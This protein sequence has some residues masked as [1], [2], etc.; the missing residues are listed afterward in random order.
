ME[1]ALADQ[2][3]EGGDVED[4]VRE[5]AAFIDGF[6]CEL[7]HHWF[8]HDEECALFAV[9]GYGRGE[10]HPKSDIDLLIL[11]KE[12]V[13]KSEHIG[14]FIRL[15]WDLKLEIGH[16]V[17][18]VRDCKNEAHRDLSVMT[19]LNERRL[20]I[21]SARLA[22]RLE[23]A[24]DSRFLWPS[25]RFFKGKLDEQIE[26]HEHFSDIEYG[27]EPNIKSSP[28]GLRD[29]QT[30]GWIARQH[31]QT[32]ELSDLI[33]HGFLTERESQTLLEG[34][35]FLWR[36]R[37]ALHLLAG[38]KEDQLY[39]ELQRD[40]AERFGYED[41]DGLLAV[42]AFMQDYYRRVL[43]LREVN[44]I[45][46]QHFT[47]AILTK[48]RKSAVEPIDENFCI[49]NHYI[50]TTGEDVFRKQPAA[51]MQIFVTMANRTDIKGVR[52]NTIRQ[53]RQHL[54][55]IDDDFRNDPHIAQLFLT[56]LKSPYTLVSQLTRMRRYGILGLYIP[57]FGRI[58][59]Q[60]QHDLFH[61]YTVDAHTMALLR[62]L[63]RMFM[64]DYD[65]D[66]PFLQQVVAEIP[67]VELLFIAGL[68]HDIGKGRGGN[69]SALG[70]V[71]VGNFCDR[72][73]I[74]GEDKELVIWLVQRHLFMSMTSQREDLTDPASIHK[75]A[76]VVQSTERLNYLL[77]LTVADIHATN[78]K[79]WNAWRQSLLMQ[80]YNA[81]LK[82]LEHG[83]YGSNERLVAVEQRQQET[84]VE[85]ENQGVKNVDLDSLW[86]DVTPT[87]VLS[88]DASKLAEIA[89][90][91]KRRSPD[92][93]G[94]VELLSSS[95]SEL[96]E[97]F[98]YTKDRPRL[99]AD[100][101][102]GLD[103]LNLNVMNANITTGASGYCYDSF[104]VMIDETSVPDSRRDERIR[105]LL[106]QVIEGNE[107][108]ERRQRR[109]VSRQLKQFNRPPRITI[110]EPNEAGMCRLEL[111]TADR[112]GLLALLSALF[113]ELNIEVHQARVTTLGERADD[114][115]IVSTNAADLADPAEA[116][117]LTDRLTE[118]ISAELPQLAL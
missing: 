6:L 60:M 53:I 43:E 45:L 40:I 88:H 96:F 105:S 22:Q 91:I 10:L 71:D 58:I 55:L 65:D 18:T 80:L 49:R 95:S 70:A 62:N 12:R 14:E 75:F 23:R 47:E 34:R 44:D 94:I 103:K 102:A 25:Q 64:P 3:W 77:A 106:Q 118:R 110:G 57:E 29:I 99:F 17:R 78:P 15:L 79:E 8:E 82:M 33:E 67:R 28:G 89:V 37:F 52:A 73:G 104:I 41:S 20:L 21:G 108:P 46:I 5:R 109:R 66:F 7:W 2:F 38:R 113:V 42:E 112:P 84:A 63:R 76:S 27:L 98:V 35:T 83:E 69:H 1:D 97:V 115:F 26:R 24:L 4:L 87:F 100:C 31:S 68:F 19:A 11:I 92:C 111:V 72:V 114:I 59:G 107:V 56:L 86:D 85:L 74:D 90:A 30:I 32:T 16:S 9:G 39:F 116:N 13:R 61:I 54:Y 117:K 93:S 81:T 101:V 50:E 51:L 48:R 36:V